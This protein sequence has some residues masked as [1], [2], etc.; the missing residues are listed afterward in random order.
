MKYLVII[1]FALFALTACS[2]N[3]FDGMANSSSNA[4]Q[5][6]AL[7]FALNDRDY[8][9]IIGKLED[10]NFK[11][12]NYD[13]LSLREKYLL[14]CAWF[15]KSGFTILDNIG[16]L[17][18][19]GE[20]MLNV[21]MNAQAGSDNLT[22]ESIGGWKTITADGNGKRGYY[23]KILDMSSGKTAKDTDMDFI[24]GLAAAMDALM[25]MAQMSNKLSGTPICFD[26]TQNCYV[27]NVFQGKSDNEIKDLVTSDLIGQLNTG[28]D[29]LGTAID[30]I[31]G[32]NNDDVSEKMQEYMDDITNNNG[33]VTPESILDFIDKYY[34]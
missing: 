33:T 6:D 10:P 16:D 1:L 20:D 19:E 24:G 29:Q 7:E 23:E 4:A 28:I 27:G 8:S 15:G 22:S 31:A 17:F 9:F 32:G 12:P 2:D 26:S 13:H 25:I 11:N 30:T 18:E 5:A 14:Q 3:I 21:L 34:R